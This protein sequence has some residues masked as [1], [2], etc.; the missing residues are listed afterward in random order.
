MKKLLLLSLLGALGSSAIAQDIEV[1]P[2]TERKT[3][4]HPYISIMGGAA[5]YKPD[6]QVYDGEFSNATSSFSKGI[7]VGNLFPL[8]NDFAIKAG[9]R[10]ITAN[11]RTEGARPRGSSYYISDFMIWEGR[12]TQLNI[13]VSLTKQWIICG[14]RI[15]VANVGLSYGINV[16]GLGNYQSGTGVGDY[17]GRPRAS[18]ATSTSFTYNS[19]DAQQ[20]NADIGIAIQP[21]KKW[22]KFTVGV[23]AFFQLNETKLKTQYEGE[24]TLSYP[25]YAETYA[26]KADYTL[27]RM[28]NIVA[29]LSYKF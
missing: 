2:A 10:V 11:T 13:P 19:T 18:A 23:N 17:G 22:S 15:L 25:T 27:K 12:Y 24:F 14:G 8:K 21:F 16:Q 29:V 7:E 1:K 3:Y 26:Y 20:L 9:I 6:V 5:L 28:S 4:F